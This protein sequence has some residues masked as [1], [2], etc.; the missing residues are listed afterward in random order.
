MKAIKITGG[1]STLAL[2][3]ALAGCGGGGGDAPVTQDAPPL[4]G[5]T[6]FNQTLEATDNTSQAHPLP[7][8]PNIWDLDLDFSL[9]DGGDDQFDGALQLAVNG[10][11]FPSDQTYSE[12]TFSG[13]Y[14]SVADGVIVAAVADN[15]YENPQDPSAPEN[16]SAWLGGI[17]DARLQQTIDLSESTGSI[18]LTW[19]DEVYL[20]SGIFDRGNDLNNLYYRVVIRDIAG[21][22]LDEVYAVNRNRSVISKTPHSE[23]IDQ[24]AGQIIV[25]S[26]EQ[27]GSN[28]IG[29]AQ[30]DAV[31]VVAGGAEQVVNGDF[32]LKN[33][34][35]WTTNSPQ[36]VQNVTS[37]VRTLA[38]L[39][40]TRSFYT[41]PNR[42]WGRWVDVF[43]NPSSDPI[44][45]DVTYTTNLGHDNGTDGFGTGMVAFTPGS[46]DKALSSWDNLAGAGD[47]DIGLVFGSGATVTPLRLP[48]AVVTADGDDEITVTYTITVPRLGRRA[49]VN[50]VVMNGVDTGEKSAVRDIDRP[51]E[52]DVENMKI[53]GRYGTDPQYREGM[54][55]E[56]IESVV[57]FF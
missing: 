40:V 33:L 49:L 51:V 36:E 29:Y 4:K 56:Q 45:V 52:I 16:W 1:V 2:F 21:N 42:L 39:S 48:T 3:L 8:Q 43:E 7:G 31:S 13:P 24:Y 53:L 25:I 17:Q 14:L 34:S 12:L 23:S 50:F 44:T 46:S 9:W 15:L 30:I 35:G 47:R 20:D 41:V 55:Q 26:F 19:T 11:S 37:G 57:N 38:G 27:R 6:T 10:E 28:L 22:L 54:T 32:E 18:D 5:G